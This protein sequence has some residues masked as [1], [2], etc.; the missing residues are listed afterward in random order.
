MRA[1]GRISVTPAA[2]FSHTKKSTITLNLRYICFLWQAVE[3]PS[4]RHILTICAC[5]VV[6]LVSDSVTLWPVAGQAS[7]SMA[8]SRQEYWGGLP[9]PSP[10]DLPN[11][12]SNPGLTFPALEGRFF[13]T[14]ATR[15]VHLCSWPEAPH[16]LASPI[17]WEGFSHYTHSSL[18]VGFS[19]SQLH[20]PQNTPPNLTLFRGSLSLK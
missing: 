2:S 5:Q 12:G 4:P 13:T 1:S 18:T 10:G 8:F 15:E 14:S 19:F 17:S 6:S 7:L 16:L 9:C 3:S 20:R 11:Q